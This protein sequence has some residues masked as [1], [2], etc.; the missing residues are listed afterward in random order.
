MNIY[1]QNGEDLVLSTL[2][3]KKRGFYVDVG[4]NLPDRDSVTLAFYE[5][6]WRGINIEPI[7]SLYDLYNSAR[8]RDINLNMGVSDK[9][10]SLNLREYSGDFHGWSSFSPSIQNHP[11]RL[12]KDYKEYKVKVRTLKSIFKEHKVKQIDFLK[13]DVEGLEY[14]V[15]SSNDWGKWRPSVI[16]I[17]NSEGKWYDYIIKQGYEMI[18]FDSLNYYFALPELHSEQILKDIFE[19]V[20]EDERAVAD[21]LQKQ[22]LEITKKLEIVMSNPHDHISNKVLLKSVYTQL[23]R[24]LRQP[25]SRSK[26]SI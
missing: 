7:T 10:G 16:V 17:E 15:L 24:K 22:I 13:V 12:E 2:L 26:I 23:H 6:G 18:F 20:I 3:P 8:P 19:S 4:A 1:S 5:K 25:L 14:E 9:N 11:T 21:D